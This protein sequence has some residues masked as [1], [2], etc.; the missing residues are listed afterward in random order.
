M[1]TSAKQTEKKGQG[2]KHK[3]GRP[4]L[5]QARRRSK[6]V[7]VKFSKIDYETLR[8]RSRKANRRL[9]EYIRETALHNEPPKP[10]TIVDADIFRNLAGVAN[11]LNQ[12]T[13]LTHQTSFLHSNHRIME[14][15]D[16]IM[17]I[18]ND[19]R[20]KKDKVKE[21]VKDT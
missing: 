1:P 17:E 13:R 8:I 4:A 9:A 10:H 7:T 21:E 18:I 19:Y 16:G 5:P 15:L 20:H 2:H 6:S 3:G 11:N 12:L 14:V